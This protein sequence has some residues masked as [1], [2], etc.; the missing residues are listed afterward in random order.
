LLC[1][2]W[3]AL[4]PAASW[5]TLSLPSGLCSRAILGFLSR[6]TQH[7]RALPRYSPSLYPTARFS[8]A[9]LTCHDTVRAHT[10]THTHTHTHSYSSISV[11]SIGRDSI[12]CALN[13]PCNKHML[14][15][16]KWSNV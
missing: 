14:S 10:H 12:N 3:D 2:L 16:H 1:S 5:C 8:T 4:S 6:L 7:K 9:F 15:P 11:S 13:L